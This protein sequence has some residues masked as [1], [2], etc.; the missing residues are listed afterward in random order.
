[1]IFINIVFNREVYL[2]LLVDFVEPRLFIN[3]FVYKVDDSCHY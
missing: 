3:I 1:M 2:I